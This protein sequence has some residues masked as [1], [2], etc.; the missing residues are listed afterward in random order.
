MLEAWIDLPL[1]AIR[2]DR[3]L[4]TLQHP[5]LLVVEDS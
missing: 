4:A 1:P 5:M 2:G 3:G